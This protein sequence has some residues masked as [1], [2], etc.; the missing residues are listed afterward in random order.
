MPTIRKQRLIDNVRFR[1]LHTAGPVKLR[2]TIDKING[3]D[4]NVEIAQI[5][6]RGLRNGVRAF[7]SEE[8]FEIRMTAGQCTPVGIVRAKVIGGGGPGGTVSIDYTVRT[9]VDA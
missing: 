4:A 6:L 5:Q 9:G 7:D 1:N 2:V 3:Q 8:P